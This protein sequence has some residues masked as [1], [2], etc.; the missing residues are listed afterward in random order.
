MIYYILS[1]VLTAVAIVAIVVWLNSKLCDFIRDEVD[2]QL[3]ERE[4]EEDEP[5][6]VIPSTGDGLREPEIDMGGGWVLYHWNGL[7][8][9]WVLCDPGDNK[10]RM[11]DGIA[12]E[13][14]EE[15][16]AWAREEMENKE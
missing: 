7:S 15:A 13:N 4:D 3:D 14:T 8:Y 2:R 10:I 6:R 12:Q 9:K 16:I 5:P 1:I 11:T